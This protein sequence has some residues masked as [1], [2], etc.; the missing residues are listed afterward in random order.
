MAQHTTD[1]AEY[2]IGVI[3]SD[4]T[5]KWTSTAAQWDVVEFSGVTAAGIADYVNGRPLLRHNNTTTSGDRAIAWDTPG[6]SA[7]GDTLILCF[8]NSLVASIRMRAVLRGEDSVSGYFGELTGFG[9]YDRALSKLVST[10]FS[11][12]DND[13]ST[14]FLAASELY[15]IRTNVVG[16]TV[17]TKIWANGDPEPGS[18]TFSVTDASIASGWVGISARNA[19][20]FLHVA[21][22][23]G[24]DNAPVQPTAP[25]RPLDLGSE[26]ESGALI[27]LEWALAAHPNGASLQY[28]G[29][30][31]RNG[32]AWTSLFPLQSDPDYEWDTDGF[33]SG[34]YEVRVRAHDGSAYGNWGAA[35]GT[36]LFDGSSYYQ[37]FSTKV[38]GAF[39]E[40]WTRRGD[41]VG[42]IEVRAAS[43]AVG[44]RR[45]QH[46]NTSTDQN[47]VRAGTV[48][49]VPAVSDVLLRARVFR[50]ATGSSGATIPQMALLAR[51]AATALGTGVTCYAAGLS[52]GAS[53]GVRIWRIV[54]GSW[55]TVESLNITPVTGYHWIEMEVTGGTEPT[56][57][58]RT[59]EDGDAV[60][61]WQLE[62]TDT[63]GSV[64]EDPG[65]VGFGASNFLYNYHLDT[66]ELV[67]EVGPILPDTPTLTAEAQSTTVAR[68]TPTLG[69]ETDSWELY[70][71]DVL[72]ESGDEGEE[73][74]FWDI[75]GLTPGQAYTWVLRA[76]NAEGHTDSAPTNLTMPGLEQH[77]SVAAITDT[78]AQ[79]VYDPLTEGSAV[80]YQTAPAA[81]T[82]YTS[83]I[84]DVLLGGG[85]RFGRPLTG[86]TID[87]SYRSRARH[88]D[89]EDWSH[90]SE[91]VWSTLAEAPGDPILS[92]FTAPEY[93][94]PLSGVTAALAWELDAGRSVTTIE[95]SGDRG[96][97]WDALTGATATGVE[98]DST[99][100]SDGFW[101]ARLTLDN[102]D[103]ILHPG[104]LIDNAAEAIYH[105]SFLP[106]DAPPLLRYWSPT[107]P[108]YYFTGPL[109]MAGTTGRWKAHPPASF[110]PTDPV[111]LTFNRSAVITAEL[112]AFTNGVG[113]SWDRFWPAETLDF[114]IAV[115]AGGSELGASGDPQAFGIRCGIEHL[116]LSSA[117]TSDPAKAGVGTGKFFLTLG[118]V[119]T[120]KTND[121]GIISGGWGP[122]FNFEVSVPVAAS[123]TQMR[124]G[125]EIH[126]CKVRPYQFYLS[127]DRPDPTNF[128]NRLDIIARVVGP[129]PLFASGRY[130]AEIAETVDMPEDVD[131]GH[132]SMFSRKAHH[133]TYSD[134][135]AI[136]V[137]RFSATA[138]ADLCV[139]PPEPEPD[140]EPEEAQNEA[141]IIEKAWAFVL[142][143]HTFYVLNFKDRPALV[144]DV[145]TGQW[146]EWF[147]RDAD[148]FPLIWN[149]FRGIMWKGQI[150]AADASLP[151]VWELDPHSMLDEEVDVIRRAVTGFQPLR[152]SA[153][154]RQGSLRLTARKEALDA[155]ATIRMRFSD[156]AG[157][158]WSQWREVT[159]LGN[160][161]SRRIEWRSLGRLR[162]P[163]RIWEI[164]DAGGLVRIDGTDTDMEG[165]SA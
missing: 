91:V 61:D 69:A 72:I 58:A 41:G 100:E 55:T 115:I 24:S 119:L 135:S 7:D 156:D 40:G 118:P 3:P 122:D 27:Q 160:S 165:G 95:I 42:W 96:A 146:H 150:I 109:C 35:G 16:T 145:T 153:A 50:A 127:V 37:D 131:C 155:P 78:S 34:V 19:V 57:R 65:L 133:S 45:V 71:D 120:A 114:G 92:R 158:T 162:A 105:D 94:E 82:G 139:D 59:W 104:F 56:I 151:T 113:Y 103:E 8:A 97:T 10:T 73:P 159:L 83:P 93:G 149:M 11:N 43:D 80:E 148:Y 130:V 76:I 84:D 99:A 102:D 138:G 62:Y 64:I 20:R 1:F 124:L 46:Q 47:V 86:L 128:P 123:W 101:I 48:D 110:G 51:V 157:R 137:R 111:E 25:G 77:L 15:W 85:D 90:W 31:R 21:V 106:G 141:E 33:L 75:T 36:T 26:Y 154:I 9:S 87:T 44:G 66:F 17:R 107:V 147:T 112:A 126:P 29:E 49:V 144:Y 12:L 164:E 152:G 52:G 68:L 134:R 89:G 28:E 70:Q 142:D 63:T 116:L 117:V 53:G 30:Y 5:H 98:F 14:G 136:V 23:T 81:D 22:G 125:S 121:N 54:N 60:P 108:R 132:V 38:L 13:G 143:G 2:E 79:L 6:A 32:G 129:S 161:V 140:D 67:G 4:W 39:P 74:A 18:W 88:H 163:G